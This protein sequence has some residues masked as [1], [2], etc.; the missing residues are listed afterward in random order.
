MGYLEI[1]DG[2]IGYRGNPENVTKYWA[3]LEPS[4][5][6]QPWCGAFVSW[7]FLRAGVLSTAMGGPMYS[8]SAMVRRAKSR[9]QWGSNPSVGDLAIY[10]FGSGVPAHVAF[11]AGLGS[12]TITD[13]GGNTSGDYVA[14]KVRQRSAVLGYWKI[15]APLGSIPAGTGDAGGGYITHGEYLAAPT[16]NA[17]GE[18]LGADARFGARGR[19]SYA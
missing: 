9:G 11:V 4:L 19:F 10:D 17:E 1:A 15:D 18:G 13:I 2:E 16:P 14:R 8:C 7:C 12:G 6:G 3:A 5:Q